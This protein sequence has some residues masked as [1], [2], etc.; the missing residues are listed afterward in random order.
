MVATKHHI[1]S[2]L[3][4]KRAMAIGTRVRNVVGGRSPLE[5]PQPPE[6]RLIVYAT[7]SISP[8]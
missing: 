5:D 1:A 8:Q 3:I 2:S 4:D 7:T 6:E